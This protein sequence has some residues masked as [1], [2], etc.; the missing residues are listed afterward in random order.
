MTLQ[1]RTALAQCEGG[2]ADK[3]RIVLVCSRSSSTYVRINICHIAVLFV[4][5]FNH[6]P[7]EHTNADLATDWCIH[8]AVRTND[9]KDIFLN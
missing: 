2:K 8:K 1:L 5:D 4:V 3:L 9:Y 7:P 6:T